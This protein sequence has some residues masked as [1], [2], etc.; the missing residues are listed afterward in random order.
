MFPPLQWDELH[1]K[2]WSW[3]KNKLFQRHVQFGVECDPMQYENKIG[4][5]EG[6]HSLNLQ[7]E[8]NFEG[9]QKPS[10]KNHLIINATCIGMPI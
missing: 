1:M 4:T 6:I 2:A 3:L 10:Q 5:I 9:V 7:G 8:N